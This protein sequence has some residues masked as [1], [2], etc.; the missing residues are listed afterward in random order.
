MKQKI[1]REDYQSALKDE[2]LLGKVDLI[3]P[4]PLLNKNGSAIIF[5]TE[6]NVDLMIKIAEECGLTQAKMAWVKT[7]PN[8]KYWRKIVIQSLIK[9]GYYG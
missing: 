8:P 1:R 5:N 9:N 6:L 7:N 4:T 2:N 3:M